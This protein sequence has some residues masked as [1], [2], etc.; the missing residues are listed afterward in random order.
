VKSKALFLVVIFLVSG[1]AHGR[2]SVFLSPGFTT[3][4]FE[5]GW[6][7]SLLGNK[8]EFE[9]GEGVGLVY[10]GRFD[11]K[12]ERFV[13]AQVQIEG[14]ALV[15]ASLG[16]GGY[17]SEERR[18]VQGTLAVMF[19]TPFLIFTRLKIDVAPEPKVLQPMIGLMFKMPV[20]VYAW[21]GKTGTSD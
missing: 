15:V 6:E 4:G 21:K 2:G 7:L 11:P 9:G 18:G 14:M 19:C 10:G 20:P 5:K 3:T 12:A 1:V 13:E 16:A 17:L 8:E